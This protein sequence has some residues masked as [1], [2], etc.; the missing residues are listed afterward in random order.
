M[1]FRLHF[2]AEDL[3]RCRFA[4]SPAWETQEAVRLLTR[5][6]QWGHH[7]P[8]L[9]RSAPAAR[10]L[11]LQ[12]LWL[13]MPARG[14]TPDF[15]APLPDSPLT[16][17]DDE[18]A[19]VRETDPELA[20]EEIACSLADTPGA[21]ESAAGRA[22]LSDPAAAV[23]ALADATTRAWE[24]LIEPYWPRLRALLEADIL[25]HTRRLGEGGLAA[26]FEGLHPQVTWADGT[27][28]VERSV[29]FSRRLDGSG[30]I[31]IPSVF[32]WPDVISGFR[33][34]WPSAVVYPARG[35][36]SLWS[37]PGPGGAAGGIPAALAR[38]LGPNRAAVLSALGEPAT[39]TA[40]ADR[41]GLAPSSVS[42]HL[43]TLRAAG[44]LTSHRVRHQ[45]RYERTPL[46]IALATGD[47]P[48]DGRTD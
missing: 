17:F 27:L 42:V 25:F 37:G 34:P 26:L 43:A 1:P 2:G 35:I 22:M 13:L 8:W 33:P 39:T 20:R 11:R 19:R 29:D 38:L 5:P 10:E 6:G 31:L 4:L 44:L 3:L 24:A 45:V 32:V 23:Q 16:S 9:R 7:L 15:L 47:V 40:L 21:A 12:R 30:L 36:G 28:T 46:G 48:G 41:L 18:I 14:Y